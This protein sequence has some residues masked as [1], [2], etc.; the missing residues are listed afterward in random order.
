MSNELLQLKWRKSDGYDLVEWKLVI[1]TSNKKKE[2]KYFGK[3]KLISYSKS[4]C[5]KYNHV[6]NQIDITKNNMDCHIP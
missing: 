1:T 5:N 3:W 6:I 4:W 2:K